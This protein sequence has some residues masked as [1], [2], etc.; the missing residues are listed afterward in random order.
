V[1]LLLEPRTTDWTGSLK[2]QCFSNY[3][4]F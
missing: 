2:L 3:R 4:L 1:A